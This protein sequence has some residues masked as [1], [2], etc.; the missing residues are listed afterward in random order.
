MT[1]S[2]A[3]ILASSK[4]FHNFTFQS[5]IVL[6]L[7]TMFP[8]WLS[9]TY[10]WLHTPSYGYMPLSNTS[11]TKHF[12]QLRQTTRQPVRSGYN[13]MTS[14]SI[15]TCICIRILEYKLLLPP[16]LYTFR[17]FKTFSKYYCHLLIYDIVSIFHYFRNI[18]HF[19]ELYRS[20]KL[21]LVAY[22]VNNLAS[23]QVQ[24]TLQ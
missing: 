21:H 22:K 12:F 2:T 8:G 3:A 19:S 15:H 14:C 17:L 6:T 4:H 20:E 13:A 5:V 23:D 24:F 10:P 7:I 1:T 16:L 11:R 18:F 9:G